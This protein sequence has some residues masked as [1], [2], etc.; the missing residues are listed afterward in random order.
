MSFG[1]HVVHGKMVDSL[2]VPDAF[3]GIRGNADS[4]W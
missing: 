4:Q 3:V 1:I 2:L